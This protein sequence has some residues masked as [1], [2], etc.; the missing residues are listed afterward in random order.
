MFREHG[1]EFSASDWKEEEEEE[2]EE[3]VNEEEE[4]VFVFFL[5]K[6]LRY[7]V[8]HPLGVLFLKF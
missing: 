2:E 5:V 7:L 4:N 1:Y 8:F 3:A 6:P